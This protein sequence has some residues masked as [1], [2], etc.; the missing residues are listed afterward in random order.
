MIDIAAAYEGGDPA[1]LPFF[2]RDPGT[3]PEISGPAP[4]WDEEFRAALEAFQQEHG[5]DAPIP[6]AAHAVVTGQQPALFCGP[7]YTM[8]KAIGAIQLA[9]ELSRRSG[10]PCAPVFWIASDDHDFE[11]ARSVHLLT[12]QDDILQLT[13]E[14]REPVAGLPMA[15]VP[16]DE[17][18]HRLV[19]RLAA[20]ARQ[21][22]G[23]GE[24]RDFLHASADA[25]ASLAEWHTRLLARLFRGTGLIL[26]SPRIPEA[27]RRAAALLRKE[28]EAPLETTALVNTAAGELAGLGF[29]PQ[30]RK[31]RT[32]CNFF[33]ETGTT[34]DKALFQE[35]RFQIPAQG[36]SFSPAEMMGLLDT[37][38]EAFSPSAALRCVAQQHLFPVQAYVAGPGEIAYWAQLRK[39]FERFDTAMPL[40]EPRPRG[41]LLR[42]KHKALLARHGR[43]AA[44]FTQPFEPLLTAALNRAAQDDRVVRALRSNG[45]HIMDAV[46]KLKADIDGEAAE[47]GPMAG[48]MERSVR[49]QLARMER[50]ATR[51]DAAR[52]ET[53]HRQM[54]R[55]ARVIAPGRRP[56]ER[57]YTPFSFVFGHGWDLV[58]ALDRQLAF[59]ARGLQE[60]EL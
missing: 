24:I 51:R 29:A 28:I 45:A 21:G 50:A 38:P 26:F 23:A 11:E 16:L 34:R 1:V 6:E 33:L 13:Y 5:S 37:R 4:V 41:V 60:V 36:T 58:P 9:R 7:M 8:Y 57:V 40:V 25:S 31:G 56:Q 53:A 32:E 3:F 52:T 20:H 44:D 2:A 59:R 22:S 30:L 14:P 39:V 15:R 10:Q 12:D 42:A 35:E 27:R 54:E 18:I 48:A 19:D 55:L 47:L 43:A 46:Q 49:R 17:H